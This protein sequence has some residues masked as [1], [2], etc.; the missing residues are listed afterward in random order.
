M[1]QWYWNDSLPE[2]LKGS[3]N[4]VCSQER[5]VTGTV[6][7]VKNITETTLQCFKRC[8]CGKAGDNLFVEK[9]KPAQVINAVDVVSVGVGKKNGINAFDVMP[10]RLFSQIGGGIN[11]DGAVVVTDQE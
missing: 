5:W 8:R 3:A 11:Q 2:Q 4:L 10:E 1:Q 7:F 6:M 9:M